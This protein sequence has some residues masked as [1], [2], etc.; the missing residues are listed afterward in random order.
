[1]RFLVI[2]R[3][4]N[5]TLANSTRD[6]A[7]NKIRIKLRAPFFPPSRRAIP[8]L[9]QPSL[10]ISLNLF[11]FLYFRYSFLLSSFSFCPLLH[12]QQDSARTNCDLRRRGRFSRT[13]ENSTHY[14]WTYFTAIT[15]VYMHNEHSICMQMKLCVMNQ[16]LLQSVRKKSR[17][18][19]NYRDRGRQAICHSPRGRVN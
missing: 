11:F 7:A 1:M 15:M 8:S 5:S 2:Y 4:C 19:F 14:R 16:R 9:S 18:M 10:S 6:D 12:L 3:P 17:E 13:P